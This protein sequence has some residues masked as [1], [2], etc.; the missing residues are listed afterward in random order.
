VHVLYNNNKGDYALRAAERTRAIAGT[1]DAG[2][3]RTA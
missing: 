3:A 2:V 1:A